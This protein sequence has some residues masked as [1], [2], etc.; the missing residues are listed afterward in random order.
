MLNRTNRNNAAV[1]LLALVM[2]LIAIPLN[3]IMTLVSAFR[4]DDE[5]RH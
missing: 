2:V 4:G 3:I 5:S 1:G